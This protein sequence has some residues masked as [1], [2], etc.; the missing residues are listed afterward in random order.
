MRKT[1]LVGAANKDPSFP[2][3]AKF[4]D[5]L[6][7]IPCRSLPSPPLTASPEISSIYEIGVSI[8]GHSP[9]SYLQQIPG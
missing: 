3:L 1:A 2:F 7:G 8:F 9:Q 6:C 5:K 4:G